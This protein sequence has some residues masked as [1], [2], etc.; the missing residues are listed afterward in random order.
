MRITSESVLDG[1]AERLFELE[2]AGD[3]VPGVLWAPDGATGPRPLLLMGHGGS[4]HKKAERLL[5]RARSFVADLGFAVAA[6]D[7]PDHGERTTP[8]QAERYAA[9]IRDRIANGGTISPEILAMMAER[10]R[11]AVPE[12]RAT[13][14]ALQ[15]LDIVGAGGPVGYW[16]VSMGTQIGVPFVAEEP[17]INAAVL[18]LFGLRAGSEVFTAAAARITI[19]LEFV[20]QRNDELVPLDAG[21]ALFD[22][23]GATEKSLHVN[24]GGHVEIPPFERDSWARF[25][26]RHLVANA[27]THA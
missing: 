27:P 26:H 18:G 13:L 15:E 1:V 23:F 14:D 2:V 25:F 12:W 11:K 7:A 9:S 8:E 4:Q 20:L 10:A 21:I 22:A 6:I 17:R 3:R 5:A 16:G 24:L 19:P